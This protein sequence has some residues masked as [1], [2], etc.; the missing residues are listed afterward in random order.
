MLH[1]W[2][3]AATLVSYPVAGQP[4]LL[5][6]H[7]RRLSGVLVFSLRG[8]TIQSV[9]VIADPAKLSFLSTQLAGSA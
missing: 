7:G 8:E 9:H 2:G 3:P 1:Y 6:F 4:A 5:G